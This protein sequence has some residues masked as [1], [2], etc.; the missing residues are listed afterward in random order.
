MLEAKKTGGLQNWRAL[1]KHEKVELKD[2]FLSGIG[3]K[4]H[5]GGDVS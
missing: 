1:K 3:E 2:M 4:L 5:F